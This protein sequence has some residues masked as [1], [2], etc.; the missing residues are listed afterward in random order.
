VKLLLPFNL[1]AAPLS[2]GYLAGDYRGVGGD[3]PARPPQE[4]PA[5]VKLLLPVNLSGAPLTRGD[6][7]P[8]G[9]YP[10]SAVIDR[11]ALRR[12]TQRK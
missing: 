10:G 11:H 8:A 5:K 9:D 1:A 2:D 6:G 12:R 4:D 7:Y 3:Q